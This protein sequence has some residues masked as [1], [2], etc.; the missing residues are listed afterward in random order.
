MPY[1]I[2]A[3]CQPKR[4]KIV[5]TIGPASAQE[6]VLRRMI[7][8]GM[9]VARLNFSHGDHDSHAD[10]IRLIRRLSDQLNVAVAILGDLRG[11]RIRVGEVEGGQIHLSTDQAI[12]L[13]PEVVMGN[14]SRLTISY[15]GLAGDLHPGD[16]LLIDDGDVV[17]RVDETKASGDIWCTV[18]EGGAVSSRRGINLP[19]LHVSLPSLTD[20]DRQD[21]AFAIEQGIDFLA[22]SFVQCAG[23]VWE[24]NQLVRDSG[25]RIPVIAKIEKKG[26]LDDLEAVVREAYGVMVARG[27]LALEMSFQEV[28]VAQKR[29]IAHCRAAAVPVITATQMLESMIERDHPTRAEATDVANAVFDGTDALMLSGETA[30]GRYPVQAIATM[31]T[32]A[33][34][35]ESAWLNGEVARPPEPALQCDV[36]STIA[37]LGHVAACDLP[38]AAIVTYTQSGSTARRLCRYRPPAPILALTPS[39]ETRRQL[40]LSWGTVPA[41]CEPIHDLAAVNDRALLEVQRHNLAHTGDAVVVLAGTPLGVPGTTNLLRVERVM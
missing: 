11:P 13:T 38:A 26:A 40:A 33:A 29:I 16:R 28:P 25:S 19:G 31:A 4:T 22:L 34:R 6:D 5:A 36:D 15:P 1:H 21:V 41:L 8:C 32:I 27:D 20:K 37:H 24:L 14:M 35:A 18:M 39:A 23:D 17:L 7:E 30:M 9:D 12:I 2:P 10:V 3:H